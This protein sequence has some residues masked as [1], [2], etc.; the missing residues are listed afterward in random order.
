[1]ISVIIPTLNEEKSLPATLARVLAQSGDYEVIVMDGGSTDRTH[2]IAAA[3]PIETASPVTEVLPASPAPATPEVAAI[4]PRFNARN[5]I[6]PGVA[7]LVIFAAV[8]SLRARKSRDNQETLEL[9]VNQA[10][11][12]VV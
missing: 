10:W 7:V 5:L 9:G 3:T 4:G 8:W 2:A 1:M 6:W 11:D 12:P